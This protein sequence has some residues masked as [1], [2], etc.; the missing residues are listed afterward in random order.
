MSSS[1]SSLLNIDTFQEDLDVEGNL[2]SSNASIS[3]S[4]ATSFLS[5]RRRSHSWSFDSQNKDFVVVLLK[6]GFP[7]N[8]TIFTC[9]SF[10]KV[11][12]ILVFNSLCGITLCKID[13]SIVI[14]RNQVSICS[15]DFLVIISNELKCFITTL[16]LF[17]VIYYVPRDIYINL[18]HNS[19]VEFVQQVTTNFTISSI[20]QYAHDIIKG[21]LVEII[22]YMIFLGS[23]F[24][25]LFNIFYPW[26][27]GSWIQRCNI[28]YLY[29]DGFVM[30]H[31]PHPCM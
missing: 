6:L 1:T 10:G 22:Q 3:L 21:L 25:G 9:H 11:Y 13:K 12:S 18:F 30:Y 17:F 4:L 7:L 28:H 23:F 15:M 20:V 2:F 16:N 27:W 24:H 8:C 31:W 26:L 29:G 14:F 19:L 5:S